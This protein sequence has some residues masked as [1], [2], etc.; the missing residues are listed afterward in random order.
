MQSQTSNHMKKLITKKLSFILAAVVFLTSACSTN[1]SITKRYHNRGFQIAWG[2]NKQSNNETSNPK[3]A[4]ISPRKS[5][6]SNIAESTINKTVIQSTTVAIPSTTV[7]SHNPQNEHH[8]TNPCYA[9]AIVK[10]HKNNHNVNYSSISGHSNSSY[11]IVPKKVKYR[12]IIKS[13]DSP[14]WGILSFV[15]GILALYILLFG[16]SL[17]FELPLTIIVGILL[18]L[19][20]MYLGLKGQNNKLELLAFLGT[21]IGCMAMVV[22]FVKAYQ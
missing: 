11:K 2:S 20:A 7:I 16:S 3:I 4:K 9:T 5:H 19:A 8:K 1:V 14:I 22:G 6:T 12:T 10:Q 21:F 18:A 17:G 15:C 13:S